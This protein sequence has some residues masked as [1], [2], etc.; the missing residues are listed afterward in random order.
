MPEEKIDQR[1]KEAL[2]RA[3][4]VQ[5]KE[6][7]ASLGLARNPFPF[8]SISSPEEVAF[9]PPLTENEKEFIEK[10]LAAPKPAILW[11]S[12]EYGSGK[13]HLLLWIRQFITD[14]GGGLLAAYYISNPGRSPTELAQQFM[15]AVGREDLSHKIRQI[16][17]R[18]FHND[19]RARGEQQVIN[20]IRLGQGTLYSQEVQHLIEVLVRPDSQVNDVAWL[21][22]ARLLF[23]NWQGVVSYASRA[24]MAEG[25]GVATV[26]DELAA[27][28][29]ESQGM[30]EHA[31]AALIGGK[32]RGTSTFEDQFRA[33]V[34][35]L[36]ASGYRKV[37]LLID[38][39]EDLLVSG[40]LT[41]RQKTDYLATLRILLDESLAQL[42]VVMAGVEA[43][44]EALKSLYAP[45]KWRTSF[46]VEL[47][48]L[49]RTVATDLVR[50]YLDR[51][52]VNEGDSIEP[53]DADAVGAA[54][55]LSEGNRRR[56]IAICYQAVE[57]AAA[58][59]SQR[60]T[61]A[62]VATQGERLPT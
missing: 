61:A 28:A 58:S 8:A 24:L 22:A 19:T 39:M 18:R 46:R 31:W 53:F 6:R 51:S 1:L 44:W 32:K 59:H 57:Q 54:V 35:V 9:L 10:F 16:V 37:F 26:C 55:K 56:F 52:R 50:R 11:I 5:D 25:V 47:P 33:L 62:H 20:E 3:Q 38:E 13:T 7:Y 42:G 30:D 49:N 45:M 12:G 34:Q 48:R 36:I 60:V 29:F 23:S 41:S 43:A 4:G 17:I 40:R 15:S 2:L 14:F 21:D 27:F